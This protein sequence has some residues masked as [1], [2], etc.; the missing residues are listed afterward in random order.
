MCVCMY[1][2]TSSIPEAKRTCV[3]RIMCMYVCMYV[4]MYIGHQFQEQNVPVCVGSCICMYICMYIYIYTH[5]H[6][7]YVP[8]YMYTY[9]S[10]IHIRIHTCH[11]EAA[12]NVT[13]ACVR[14]HVHE[15]MHYCVCMHACM[16]MY[17][18]LDV[19]HVFM[20][21]CMYIHDV[22]TNTCS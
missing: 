16:C 12:V 5:T 4:Y 22:N 17:A 6:E 1:V 9:T 15:C 8:V 2:Y 18:R 13:N 21:A 10:N 3:C 19:L 14:V 20:Y 7:R 11:G